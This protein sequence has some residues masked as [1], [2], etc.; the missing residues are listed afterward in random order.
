MIR[1]SAG[2]DC[3][4][5]IW[6]STSFQIRLFVTAFFGGEKCR[7]RT[8]I[9]NFRGGQLTFREYILFDWSIILR[10]WRY[11]M[12]DVPC[13]PSEKRTRIFIVRVVNLHNSRSGNLRYQHSPLDKGNTSSYFIKMSHIIINRVLFPATIPWKIIINLANTRVISAAKRHHW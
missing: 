12:T 7:K 3:N 4:G 11:Q 9:K 2:I 1:V 10:H 13:S 6:G 5:Q 8:T